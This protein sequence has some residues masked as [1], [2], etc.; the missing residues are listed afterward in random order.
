[1]L[2]RTKRLVK[3]NPVLW[4]TV[5]KVRALAATLRLKAKPPASAP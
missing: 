5:S 2:R 3:Q 1:M 4:R